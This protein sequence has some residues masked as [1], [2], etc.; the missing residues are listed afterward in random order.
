MSFPHG[1]KENRER[2]KRVSL[3]KYIKTLNR[4]TGPAL[5]AARFLL[6][7]DRPSPGE[8]GSQRPGELTSYR[9][10]GAHFLK[11]AGTSRKQ[12]TK[13]GGPGPI[14]ERGR[15]ATGGKARRSGDRPEPPTGSPLPRGESR[16]AAGPNRAP[17]AAH[18]Q[19]GQRAARPADQR[20]QSPQ[21]SEAAAGTHFLAA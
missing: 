7:W 2:Q 1:Y 11:A 20:A 15:R 12:Q 14:R 21:R 13:R 17:Q 4:E 6:Q 8:R 3:Y 9:Q 10:R 16:T 18:V 5:L 19:R